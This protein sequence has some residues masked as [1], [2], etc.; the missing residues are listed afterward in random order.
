MLP[1]LCCT[2]FRVQLVSRLR[3]G[4]VL[5]V[6]GKA[7][8]DHSDSEDEDDGLELREGATYAEVRDCAVLAGV[9][10]LPHCSCACSSRPLTRGSTSRVACL[11]L[12]TCTVVSGGA[13]ARSC[14][15]LW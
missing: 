15:R 13:C 4:G 8:D 9:A 5:K 11:L 14:R 10:S 6:P 3:V 12:L 7:E 1:P 2:D